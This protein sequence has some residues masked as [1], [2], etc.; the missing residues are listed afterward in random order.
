MAPHS[1]NSETPNAAVAP[2]L[3]GMPDSPTA[4]NPPS[5]RGGD[6]RFAQNHPGG[7][8]NPFARQVAALRLALLNRVTAEDIEEVLAVLLIKAKTGDLAAIKLL[9]S[10]TIGKPGPAVDPDPLDQQEWQLHQQAAVPPAAVE[11]LLASLPAATANTAARSAWPC[12]AQPHLQPLIRGLHAAEA[13]DAALPPPATPP[14]SA[15]PGRSTDTPLNNPTQP[16]S[17][18]GV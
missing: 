5:G 14:P 15:P 1:R 9:L 13:G 6:G 17:A 8:G 10:Y 18:N 16:P 4:C 2:T 11:D 12:A 3:Q 7:P